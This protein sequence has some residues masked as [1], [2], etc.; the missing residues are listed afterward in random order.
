MATIQEKNVKTVGK[1]LG[2]ASKMVPGLRRV[3]YEER[4]RKLDIPTMSYRRR[5]DRGVQGDQQKVRLRGEYMF[6]I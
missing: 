2:R 1:V 3:S 6:P 4:I 5:H